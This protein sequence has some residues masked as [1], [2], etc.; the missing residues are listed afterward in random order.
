MP[1]KILYI[2][3]LNPLKGPGAISMDH[4]KALIQDGYQVDF[5]TMF[6]VEGHPEIRHAISTNKLLRFLNYRIGKLRRHKFLQLQKNI[7]P[8]NNDGP[9]YY[10]YRKENEPPI[11]TRTILRKIDKNYD[12]III[13]F[14]QGLLSYETLD[15]IFEKSGNNPKVYFINADYSTM[16]GG[17]HFFCSCRKFET[18]CGC[19]P[20]ISSKDPND[21]TA[22]NVKYR[23]KIISKI[24]PYV[25]I[26]GFTQEYF[27]SSFVLKENA[28]FIFGSVVLDMEKFKPMDKLEFRKKYD[29]QKD[30]FIILV[31]AQSFAEERKG[32]K[33][34]LKALEHLYNNLT[35]VDREKILIVTIGNNALL[36]ESSLFNQRNL[37]YLPVNVLPE[38]YSMANVF[39]SP[40]VNDPGPSMVN[41][42][43]AC[44]T[45]VVSFEMGTA[46]DVIKNQDSG[47]CVPLKDSKAMAKAIEKIFKMGKKE[48]ER[49]RMSAR[50]TALKLHSYK[51]F[52]DRINNILQNK[53]QN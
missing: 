41:Q 43:I 4:V 7:K 37:G 20:M 47:I 38:I 17:C 42:S 19:C 26:N 13:F 2:S 3:S 12:L 53:P 5:L 36:T 27:K 21:F 44:G 32:K 31:G 40:S 49:M 28:N 22:W 29:I 9:F 8:L 45:P 48:Y 34:F 35:I 6:P 50:D 25:S 14:W 33:Y 11:P 24:K 15:K 23:K 39:V 51:S 10:F 30:K 52:T 16:T 1:K 46:L 18:G